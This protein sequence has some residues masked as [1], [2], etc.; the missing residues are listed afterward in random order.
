MLS[1]IYMAL[2]VLEAIKKLDAGDTADARA[3][4]VHLRAGMLRDTA[5]GS[6]IKATKVRVDRCPECGPHGN[7][8]RVML[9]DSWVDCTTCGGD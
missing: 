8:G 6:I 7:R 2:S 3:I 9:F 5:D 4:L 1:Y